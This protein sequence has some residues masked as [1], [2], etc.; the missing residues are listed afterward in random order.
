VRADGKC[1]FP[2]ALGNFNAGGNTADNNTIAG[3]MNSAFPT[4]CQ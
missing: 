3:A 4:T 2:V 1:E